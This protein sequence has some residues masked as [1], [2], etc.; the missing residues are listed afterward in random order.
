MFAK[1][2][3]STKSFFARLFPHEPE[4]GRFESGSTWSLRGLVTTAPMVAPSRE[5]LVYIPKGRSIWRRAPLIV[6][7]H[8][9]RQTPEEIA[10]LLDEA[11]NHQFGS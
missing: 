7:C 6:L 4:P 9:C 2:W 3:A 11:D 10:Q 1:L 5:Y 8:G